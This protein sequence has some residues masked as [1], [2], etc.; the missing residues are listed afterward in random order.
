M[1][2]SELRALLERATDGIA[3]DHRAEVALAGARRQ[4]V[5]RRSAAAVLAAAATVALA[6]GVGQLSSGGAR[7]DDPVDTPST[8]LPVPSPAPSATSGPATQPRWDPFSVPNAPWRSRGLP[9]TLTAPSSADTVPVSLKPMDG[10]VVA[11]PQED[12]DLQLLGTDGQ[13]RSVP[14]TQGA[15][16]GALY[17]TVTPAISSDGTRVAMSTNAGILVVDV[18]TGEDTT[19]PWPDEIAQPWDTAPGLRWLPGDEGFVVLHWRDTWLVDLDGGDRR[20]P[21]KGGYVSIGVDPEGVIYQNDY[22]RRSLLSWQGDQRIRETP[23]I[24]CERLVGGYGLLAC[25]AGS[26]EPFRSGPIVVDPVNGDVL[27]Y[28]PIKDPNSIYS[29]NGHLTAMGFLDAET[30]LLLV[31]PTDF[32]TMEVGEESWHLVAWEF[33][34]GAFERITSGD[35]RLQTI[36]VAPRLLDSRP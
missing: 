20:A 36:A 34:T 35:S 15:V 31:G 3:A 4:R 6:I 10:V 2:E 21:Y 27:A 26:V 29:D 16:A 18:T 28:A 32:K 25:T 11:W 14:G 23:F 22:Q 30:V 5:R 1:R 19:I 17:D 12:A 7:S 13:W 9:E 33:R 8:S 24:Q